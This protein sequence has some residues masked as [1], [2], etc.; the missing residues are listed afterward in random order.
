MIY[1]KDGSFPSQYRYNSVFEYMFVFSK[2]K[3]KNINLLKEPS[4]YYTTNKK[5]TGHRLPDGS[6]VRYRKHLNKFRNLNNV[7]YIPAGYN[8]STVDKIAFKHP[9]IFPEEVARRHIL[10]WSNSYDIVLD[11]MCGSGT[12][13]KI[14]YLCNRCFIGMDISKTYIR[15]IAEPR[16][17]ALKAKQ[18]KLLCC[19]AIELRNINYKYGCKL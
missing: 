19:K 13:C 2:G 6:L 15:E 14:A 12:V 3:P 10:T 5:H 4:K 11:P 17:L 7:W 18:H 1:Q 9:A 8:K 16:L